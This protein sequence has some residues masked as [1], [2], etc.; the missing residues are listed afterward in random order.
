MARVDAC[1]RHINTSTDLQKKKE[2]ES[3]AWRGRG[4]GV[5]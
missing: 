3:G 2:A 1:P 4:A 5:L